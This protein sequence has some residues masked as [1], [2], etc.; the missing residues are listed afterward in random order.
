MAIALKPDDAKDWFGKPPPD[1]TVIA[2]SRGVDWLY[3]YLRGFYRDDTK[4]TGWNNTVFP[5]VGM[6]HV[7][8][9]L[10]GEQ[11]MVTE[12]TAHGERTINC[13]WKSRAVVADSSTTNT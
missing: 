5:H 3:S 6:P 4:A 11:V 12:K 13:T 2:R 8:Y 1:L 10:Q 9:E 7:M